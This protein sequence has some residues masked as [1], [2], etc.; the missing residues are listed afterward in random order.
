MRRQLRL[1]NWLYR[2]DALVPLDRMNIH[3][4]IISAYALILHS[5]FVLLLAVVALLIAFH[6]LHKSRDFLLALRIFKVSLGLYEWTVCYAYLLLLDVQDMLYFER[7][8]E[9]F[10]PEC[11]R[12]LDVLTDNECKEFCGLP[13][14]KLRRLL[15]QLRLPEIIRSNGCVFQ[16]EEVF[17]IFLYHMRT[18]DT[19]LKMR[20][21]FGGDPRRFTYMVRWVADHLYTTFYNKISG[22][23]LNQWLPK[24]D[25]FRRA[26]HWRFTHGAVLEEVQYDNHLLGSQFVFHELLLDDFRVFGFVDDSAVPTAR[27]G[28]SPSRRE[29]FIHDLQRSFYR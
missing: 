26:I 14:R 19:F 10:A 17:I 24:I 3:Q 28:D 5:E 4:L 15:R 25:E 27:P 7:A 8:R 9:R 13:R 21:M 23:S 2:D 12:S 29:G 18:G 6:L 1:T 16:K 22:K 11:R 20:F